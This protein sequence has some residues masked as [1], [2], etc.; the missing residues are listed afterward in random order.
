MDA[1]IKFSVIIVNYN[2]G[3]YLAEAL[4]SLQ[5]QT[6]KDFEVLLIDNASEDA[7][8][9]DLDQD[10]LRNVTVLHQ[11]ENLGFAK[12]NNIGA[13]AAKG[14]WLALL[15]PDAQAAPDWLET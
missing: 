13:S 8:L 9:S 7:S 4:R 10:L 11:D 15:N 5:A 2:S 3:D 14:E 12:A 1:P 6:F